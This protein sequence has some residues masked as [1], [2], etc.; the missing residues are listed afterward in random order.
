MQLSVNVQLPVVFGGIDG[1]AVYVDTEGSFAP[2]R[3]L[4]M[5]ECLIGARP[6]FTVNTVYHL[7]ANVWLG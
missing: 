3:T 5:A 1:D 7:N 6:C 2:S 4:Q